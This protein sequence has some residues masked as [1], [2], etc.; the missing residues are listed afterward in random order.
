MR[1]IV[2][3]K[4]GLFELTEVAEPAPGPGEILVRVG[5]CGICGTV[6]P[7]LSEPMPIEQFDQALK[8]VRTGEGV[9]THIRP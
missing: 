5:C 3:E 8:R 9:K 1:A 2:V 6:R 4:P 7:L